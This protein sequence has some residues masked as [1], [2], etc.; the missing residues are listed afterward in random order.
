M[1]MY[2]YTHTAT[3]TTNNNN[4]DDT[5]TTKGLRLGDFVRTKS[6]PRNLRYASLRHE[7]GRISYQ[8]DVR[9]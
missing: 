6:R 7:N 4:D 8:A 5:H 1:Y 2:T 9:T 3:T